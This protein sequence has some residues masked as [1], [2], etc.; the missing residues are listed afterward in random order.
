M[1]T[2][3]FDDNFSQKEKVILTKTFKANCERLDI[4]KRDCTVTVRR[5]HNDRKS[6]QGMMTRLSPDHFLVVLNSNSFNLF[7]G[8]S[9]LGHEVVHVAQ[10]LRGDLTDD[11]RGSYWCG[12]HFP[13]F[14]CE[15]IYEH[16][17]WEKEAFELQPKLH[18]HSLKTLSTDELIHVRDT[19][20]HAFQ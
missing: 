1:A 16:L 20:R 17:P 11:E 13:G 15:I 14:L 4:D 19:S 18:E 6:Q 10:Y 8:I 5:D 3:L 9:V 2:I 12:Q 7:N